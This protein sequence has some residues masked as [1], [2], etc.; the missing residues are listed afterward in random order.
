LPEAETIIGRVYPQVKH[1]GQGWGRT[2]DLP[3]YSIKDG[4]PRLAM[5]VC[6]PAQNM[7][8]ARERLGCTSMYETYK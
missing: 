8:L 7:T 1:G 6:L 3:L 2:A 4:S 5:L